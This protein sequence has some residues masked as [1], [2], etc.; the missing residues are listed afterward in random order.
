[1][2][3]HEPDD[4][5][6]HWNLLGMAAAGAA[7]RRVLGLLTED[8]LA[9]ALEVKKETLV[10]W[11]GA[12]KGPDYTKLG[13]SVYYRMEDVRHWAGREV[14]MLYKHRRPAPPVTSEGNEPTRSV[15]GQCEPVVGQN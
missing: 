3:S 6:A 12:Q 15:S 7:L 8:E 5:A 2:K 13:R 14:V 1:M 10:Q 11:R 9:A 4:P